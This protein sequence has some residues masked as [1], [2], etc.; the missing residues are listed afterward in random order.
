MANTITQNK[1]IDDGGSG[2]KPGRI[3]AILRNT[4]KKAQETQENLRHERHEAVVNSNP[5]FYKTTTPKREVVA[6]H[7]VQSNQNSN[8]Q[9][10]N[11]NSII[12]TAKRAMH[13]AT[14]SIAVPETS[15]SH[16]RHH[17]RNVLMSSVKNA[18]SAI[19]NWNASQNDAL[20]ETIRSNRAHYY[21]NQTQ[22]AF[23]I[24]SLSDQNY[25]NDVVS[26]I[27][28]N[29]PDASMEY[30]RSVINDIDSSANAVK[31]NADLSPEQNAQNYTALTTY[32]NGLQE[33]Y[34]ALAADSEARATLGADVYELYINNDRETLKTMYEDA[35]KDYDDNYKVVEES[36]ARGG[37]LY[38][39]VVDVAAEDDALI[40]ADDALIKANNLKRAYEYADALYNSENLYATIDEISSAD[41][42]TDIVAVGAERYYNDVRDRQLDQAIFGYTYGS[43]DRISNGVYYA[44]FVPEDWGITEAEYQQRLRE[45]S[46]YKGTVDYEGDWNFIMGLGEKYANVSDDMS[47]SIY[48]DAMNVYYALYAE[49]P[50]KAHEYALH[51]REAYESGIDAAIY[52]WAGKNTGTRLL[53]T[54]GN[55]LMLPATITE[56]AVMEVVAVEDGGELPVTKFKDTLMSGASAG[57]TEKG[58]FNRGW[59]AGTLDESIPVIGGKGLGDAYQIANSDAISRVGGLIFG[60]GFAVGLG[61]SAAASDYNQQL[62]MGYD[63]ETARVH[64]IAAG[65]A[66]TLSEYLSIDHFLKIKDTNAIWTVL[67]KQSVAEASEE[68]AT[69]IVNRISD[70]IIHGDKSEWN[71]NRLNYVSLGY[72][73]EEAQKLADRDFWEEVAYDGISAALS[74]GAGSLGYYV[75]HPVQSYRAETQRSVMRQMQRFV[76]ASKTFDKNTSVYK[77]GQRVQQMLDNKQVLTKEGIRYLNRQFGMTQKQMQTIQNVREK[78]A[79]RA[80]VRAEATAAAVKNPGAVVRTS[81][82]YQ[83]FAKTGAFSDEQAN[84]YGQTLDALLDGKDVSRSKINGLAKTLMSEAGA[85]AVS[86]A[87]GIEVPRASSEAEARDRLSAAV[88][89]YR[90][91]VQRVETMNVA[92]EAS[93]PLKVEQDYTPDEVA[94]EPTQEGDNADYEDENTVEAAKSRV[95]QR[96]EEQSS[97]ATEQ[98]SDNGDGRTDWDLFAAGTEDSR[99]QKER[100]ASFER[101]QELS[102]MIA[103]NKGKENP[104][105]DPISYEEFALRYKAQDPDATEFESIIA[106]KAYRD[107]LI[108]APS[109]V[110]ARKATSWLGKKAQDTKVGKAAQ[111]VEKT[112]KEHKVEKEATRIQEK[113]RVAKIINE[114]ETERRNAAEK[115]ANDKKKQL[116]D[117]EK[118][119]D[120]KEAG[121]VPNTAADVVPTD[122]RERV[123][124]LAKLLDVTIE[125]R[126]CELTGE[127]DADKNAN[128]WYDAASGHIVLDINPA[129]MSV[130]GKDQ[131]LFVV[132]HEVGHA[133]KQAMGNR[134]SSFEKYAVNLMGK[135]AVANKQSEA[136]VYQDEAA[137]REDVA[138]D[139]IG[140]IMS[141]SKVFDAFISDIKVGK[142]GVAPVRGLVKAFRA[143]AN[144]LTGGKVGSTGAAELAKVMRGYSA[145]DIQR[146]ADSI[147]SVLSAVEDKKK[148]DL[149]KKKQGAETKAVRDAR[150]SDNIVSDIAEEN[151]KNLS[152]SVRTETPPTKTIDVYKLM[153][154]GTDGKL[155]PLFIDG[156]VG[157]DVGVWQNA[158]SPELSSLK[159]L[160]SGVYLIDDK[161]GKAQSMQAYYAELGS[162]ANRKFPAK[163]D[164]NA[165][166]ENGKRWVFIEEVE[167][168]QRRY[169]GES[170][171]YWNIGINGSGSVST[172]AMRPGWHAGSLP[173][174]RQIGKGANKNLRDDTFVWVKGRMAADV[175]YQAE[176]NQNPDGDIPT[177]VPNN[178]YYMMATNPNKAASQADRIGWYISGAFV[179]DEIISDSAARETIDKWNKAHPDQT[180]EYDYERESGKVFDAKTMSLVDAKSFSQKT[181]KD[182]LGNTLSA[183]QQEYFKDSKVRDAD[184]NLLV[185]YHGTPNYGFNIFEYGRSRFGLF[186]EGFY[187]T[188]DKNVADGYADSD[189]NTGGTYAV[190]LNISNAIDMDATADIAAWTDAL[191]KL[192]N[193]LDDAEMIAAKRSSTAVIN[194]YLK[195]NGLSAGSVKNSDMFT[196]LKEEVADTFSDI[197]TSEAG[198]IVQ[199]ALIGMGYDGITHIGGGRYNKADINRHRVYIAFDSEQVKRTDNTTP[200]TNPDMRYSQKTY[201]INGVDKK[202][203]WVDGNILANKRKGEATEAYVQRYLTKKLRSD[204]YFLAFVTSTS[205]NMYAEKKNRTPK[206]NVGLSGKYTHSGYNRGIK[207]NAPNIFRAKMQAAEV[208]GDI[209]VVSKYDK[210]STTQGHS[211]NKD[212]PGGVHYYNSTFVIP[213]YDTNGNIIGIEAYDCRL[214]VDYGGDGKHYLYDIQKISRNKQLA[215]AILQKERQNAQNSAPSKVASSTANT[216]SIA[217]SAPNVNTQNAKSFSQKSGNNI[218]DPLARMAAQRRAKAEADARNSKDYKEAASDV[219]EA[220]AKY[221]AAVA[222]EKANPTPRPVL[223]KAEMDKLNEAR[224]KYG[225]IPEGENAVRKADIP[226]KVSPDKKVSEFAR[227]AAES[228]ITNDTILPAVQSLILDDGMSYTPDS[229]DAQATRAREWFAGKANVAK[230]YTDW[231]TDKSNT[232]DAMMRGMILYNKLATEA[233]DAETASARQAAT[234]QAL[235]VLQRMK[236][237]ATNFAQALQLIKV[238]NKLSPDHQAY[239]VIE[240]VKALNEELENS[241]GK[242]RAAHVKLNTILMDQWMAAMKTRDQG[243]INA[244]EHQLL[245]DIAAQVPAT[246]ADKWNAWRYLCMLGNF[247]TIG[248][249]Y[250]GNWGMAAL[251]RTATDVQ[252]IAEGIAGLFSKKFKAN[253]DATG[254]V[255]FGQT[256]RNKTKEGK[257]LIAFSE[258]YWDTI[259]D[260][261]LDDKY[262]DEAGK[263]KDTSFGA[264]M[265]QTIDETNSKFHLPGIKQWQSITNKALNEGVIG[266][267]FFIK[268]HFVN[269][270]AMVCARR[271]ITAEMLNSGKVSDAMLGDIMQH[272]VRMAREATFHDVNAFSK[273]VSKL[274]IDTNKHPGIGWRIG[275]VALEGQLPFKKTPANVLVRSLEY[276]PTGLLKAILAD[277]FRLKTGKINSNQYLFNLS[278]G[279]TGTMVMGLGWLLRSLGILHGG[280]DDDEER[281]GYQDYSIDAFGKNFTLDWLAPAAVPLFMGATLHDGFEGVTDADGN[282]I[283]FG[284][285]VSSL[286]SET[287]APVMEM[288]ML[289]GIQDTISIF[290]NKYGDDNDD[291]LSNMFNALVVNNAISYLSQAIPTLS[292]QLAQ[293]L[294]TEQERTYVG[295]IADPVERQFIRS[296]IKV[297]EK[298]PFHDA[299]QQPYVDEFGRTESN[300]NFFERF[301]NAFVWPWYSSDIKVTD[302]DK[303]LQEVAADSGEKVAPTARGYTVTVTKYDEDG[304]KISSEQ[305][306]LNGDQYTAYSKAYGEKFVAM[307]SALVQ[308]DY[309]QSLTDPMAKAKAIK[310]VRD[311]ANEYGK[312]AAGVGY[313]VKD[314]KLF[315]IVDMGIPIEE[316]YAAKVYRTSID[317]IKGM[318]AS[319]KMRLY[320]NYIQ[321]AA[322][323]AGWTKEQTQFVLDQYGTFFSQVPGNISKYSGID[324]AV[325]NSDIALDISQQIDALTPYGGAAQVADWQKWD[326]IASYPGLT[327]K[328]KHD[329]LY[330][331][332]LSY[333]E[334]EEGADT[335][336]SEAF[337]NASKYGVTVRQYVNIEKQV[338]QLKPINGNDKVSISQKLQVVVNYSGLNDSQRY[339]MALRYMNSTQEAKFIPCHDAGVPTDVYINMYLAT[340][341]YAGGSWSQQ[342]VKS[343][344]RSMGYSGNIYNAL[345]N[346]FAPK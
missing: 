41:N 50:E 139:F 59:L 273:L 60:P 313:V 93:V 142:I 245:L 170:R 223:S 306:R 17:A 111:A 248:R 276:G 91:A 21:N 131:Y 305:V 7:A 290:T 265:R 71:E 261:V 182:S 326:V 252:A 74:A 11:P 24:N 186:G 263:F 337:A 262:D 48:R 128:G 255:M 258:A 198:E 97:T 238:M 345:Y 328:E 346:A 90:Q 221:D 118:F 75:A 250:V 184:G 124:T 321:N 12:G 269:N 105:D 35:Q 319:E 94:A 205:D 307:A 4:K 316:A 55:I 325:G 67:F 342:E 210:K 224:N 219:E 240:S 52:E 200:T 332:L 25:L 174:M 264:K 232:K 329:A 100:I 65:A 315:D 140:R 177:H 244:T 29:N 8:V 334:V 284:T 172:F 85:Q 233:Q 23:S 150:E 203:A 114:E 197:S 122:I 171:K 125:Y 66:E 98:T 149:L 246:F 196:L 320:D 6:R 195:E 56:G 132:A 153:R 270:F 215:N 318:S 193:P 302:L 293:T 229:N 180:V 27:D 144:K 297:A 217:Q 199:G 225:V 294:E 239:I 72:S 116:A 87:L 18:N 340:S 274:R 147:E 301:L 115:I 61:F 260:A 333:D 62:E 299:R 303:E 84:E 166:A 236:N 20:S 51:I 1:A 133:A 338:G 136:S 102:D 68:M 339:A 220:K 151:Q 34:N 256:F 173:S 249:N 92:E 286:F 247:K 163:A 53:S 107:G 42:Y 207:N 70:G 43:N 79:E 341:T 156:A 234:E 189:G 143:I 5:L 336:K 95:Q 343:Y 73:Q 86:D 309:Y 304:N 38:G 129:V 266:D 344:L 242:R 169:G 187:F 323:Q 16:E 109:E 28:R 47:E 69:D 322:A 164:V 113:N 80:R 241:V 112:V 317:N 222:A 289:S 88:D 32:R 285:V 138:C 117:I 103:E 158:D 188:D 121:V 277:T 288:S 283:G 148:A 227:T 2:G 209:A 31:Y 271:G 165:A 108:D 327:E 99:N 296:I 145:A 330:A 243:Y 161:T 89:A 106:Y 64:A 298:L 226:R 141:D 194:A 212:A 30:V 110:N 152:Y 13:T 83:S 37:R 228:E 235:D 54:I 308:S 146:M 127:T 311:L 123:D 275:K 160:Q 253:K 331:Y 181:T 272:S 300:G 324:K 282:K 135:N 81:A 96:Q 82:S 231:M 237:M 15:N 179:A 162:N 167:R 36:Y 204:K 14:T 130:Y 22:T 295:D 178:G 257:A 126:N 134:W 230:A 183:G 214:I 57:L 168:E 155:Y 254:T 201:N 101:F 280:V 157:V 78:S 312:I 19:Q 137:A 26:H 33:V 49:D 58:L 192:S 208:L 268:R 159:T 292:S 104:I 267:A 259:S 176:A 46:R 190:Y 3:A 9:A 278:K 218:T 281:E 63:S 335:T 40:K 175:D 77:E 191:A 251:Q 119:K 310:D 202:V 10:A 185:M 39:S 154:L 120:Y 76:D 206:Q 44:E 45:G 314:N 287:F 291:I 216:T 213:R 279:L 211:S